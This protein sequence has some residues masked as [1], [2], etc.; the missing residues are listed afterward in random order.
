VRRAA[1]GL[2]LLALL[3]ACSEDKKPGTADGQLVGL[4]QQAALDPC[5][6]GIGDVPHLVLPCL[7]GGPDVVLDSGPPAVPTLVN[8]YATWSGPCKDEMPIL[9]E[10]REKA[11]TRVGLLGVDTED[12]QRLALLFAKDLGQHWPAVVDDE[13]AVLRRYGAG[14]PLTLFVDTKGTVVYVHHGAFKDLPA[15][16][17]EVKRRLGVVV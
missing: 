4:R 16:T 1:A 12:E 6:T 14:A 10:F 11:G 5:P 7:G 9:A 8:V 15:L 13:G 17:A 3:S 2:V